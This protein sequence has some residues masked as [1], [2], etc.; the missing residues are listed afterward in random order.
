M[1]LTIVL[2]K[3]VESIEIATNL[4]NIVRTK[5]EDHPDIAITASVGQNIPEP[6]PPQ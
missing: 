6:E 2:R 5:L 3:E 4:T 1:N